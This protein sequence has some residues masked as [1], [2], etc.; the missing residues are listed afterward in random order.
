[1]I[2][3]IM[4][5][6]Q[7][8]I[9]IIGAGPGGLFA[10][11]KIVENVKKNIGILIIDKGP[12]PSERSCSA[13]TNRC[14]DCKECNLISGGGGAGLFSD[15]KLIFDLNSGGYLKE[16]IS[17]EFKNNLE[18]E[19]KEVIWKFVSSYI[20]KTHS[21]HDESRLCF[22]EKGLNFK[23]YPVV[24]LGSNK[25]REFTSALI[26]YLQ[27]RNVKFLFNT[28]VS[29]ITRNFSNNWTI[30][31][32][33]NNSINTIESEYLIASVGK[34]G[35]FWFSSLVEEL[36][37]KL[38]D[39]K[40]YIGVR[41]EISD[42]AAKPL[43]ELSLDPKI[44]QCIGNTKIK[45]HCFCRHGQILLLKYYS[46]PLAGGHTPFIEIDK[47]FS[48]TK[49]PNSNFGILFH[50]STICTWK[51]AIECMKKVNKITRGNLLVQRLGDY[52]NDI[53]TTRQKLNDNTI[54]PSNINTTPGRI[55]EDI[56]PGFKDK[57]LSFL[58]RLASCIPDI[59]NPD[60]LIYAPAIEWW[61]RKI[62]INEY[63]EVHNLPNLY[64]IGDGSGWIQGI[65]Q[66]A[67][68]GII[69]AINILTKE[70][71]PRKEDVLGYVCLK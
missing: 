34:E 54:K 68:T 19:V 49:F 10:A 44:S 42:S 38:E 28:K 56:L 16:F 7:F 26:S 35:N 55:S 57:F 70:N 71:T 13:L 29:T 11:Y 32:Q 65:V 6:Q 61:M 47:N 1:M 4:S 52:L 64:V 43:Y 45:T 62:V 48:L 39:N 24:H 69:A 67:A 30:K 22:E 53:P 17:S 21:S 3:D 41:L 46:L 15:G 66:S 9:V 27:Q 58:E 37:G 23:F 31:V 12:A 25:L 60:N 18:K 14:K 59:M 63:M 40:T 2:N 20:Y 8:D 50:D 36:G 33:Y 5:A 51:R